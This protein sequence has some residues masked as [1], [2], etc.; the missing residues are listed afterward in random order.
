VFFPI[1]EHSYWLWQNRRN[2]HPIEI[3]ADISPAN[4]PIG[5]LIGDTNQTTQFIESAHSAMPKSG[6][7]F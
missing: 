7:S 2:K 1:L 4:Q 6:P 3:G 5:M